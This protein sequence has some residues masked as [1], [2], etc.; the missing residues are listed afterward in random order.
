MS[1]YKKVQYVDTIDYENKP[2]KRE[3]RITKKTGDNMGM[4]TEKVEYGLLINKV[5]EN[6]VAYNAGLNVGDIITTVDDIAVDNYHLP[7]LQYKLIYNKV[8]DLEIIEPRLETS[9][10]RV[11]QIAASTGLIDLYSSLLRDIIIN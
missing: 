10:H 7:H 2:L 3:M 8:I 6:G 4:K 5:I 11:V 1:S 9:P